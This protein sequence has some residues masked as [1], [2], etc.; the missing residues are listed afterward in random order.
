MAMYRMPVTRPYLRESSK[1]L[2]PPSFKIDQSRNSTLMRAHYS[3]RLK[4][5]P[6]ESRLCNIFE[7]TGS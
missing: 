4:D 1:K 5:F 3:T 7:N 2:V 6:T